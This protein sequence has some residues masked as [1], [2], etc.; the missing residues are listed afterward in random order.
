MLAKKTVTLQYG[1]KKKDTYHYEYNTT[2]TVCII[3][4]T[5]T[6][7]T[8]NASTKELSVFGRFGGSVTFFND[9]TPIKISKSSMPNVNYRSITVGDDVI[10]VFDINGTETYVDQ[11]GFTWDI[12]GNGDLQKDNPQIKSTKLVFQSCK[13]S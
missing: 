7:T 9:D 4:A 6:L 12:D 10:S 11:D 1:L 2:T 13:H 3:A 8:A 5:I